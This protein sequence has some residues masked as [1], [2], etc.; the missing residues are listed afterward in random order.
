MRLREYL[1]E[2]PRGEIT[3]LVRVTG[4]A[5]STLHDVLNGKPIRLYETAKKISEATGGKVGIADLCEADPSIET[6]VDD[7][8]A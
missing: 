6:K 8:A 4:V 2:Q 1:D 5:N 7:S 3:R